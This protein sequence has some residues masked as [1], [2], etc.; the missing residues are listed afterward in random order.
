[1][2]SAQL[3]SWC[4]SEIAKLLFMPEEDAKGVAS[5]VLSFPDENAIRDYLRVKSFSLIFLI[6]K[7]QDVLG[8]NSAFTDELIERRFH[9]APSQTQGSNHFRSLLS[10]SSF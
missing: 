4:T 9:P 7:S 1:M 8:T 5:Y 10:F 6:L 3:L 2:A